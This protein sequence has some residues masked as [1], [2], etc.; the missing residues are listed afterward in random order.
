MGGGGILSVLA[1]GVS[2]GR[3]T[4][5]KSAGGPAGSGI[6]SVSVSSVSS[7]PGG[8]LGA[9]ISSSDR[10]GKSG[11]LASFFA[12]LASS[13]RL[14]GDVAAFFLRRRFS[15]DPR[16]ISKPSSGTG[17][18]VSEAV[19]LLAAAG[20]VATGGVLI[21]FFGLGAAGLAS[22]AASP[23]ARGVFSGDFSGCMVAGDSSVGLVLKPFILLYLILR[24]FST[25]WGSDEIRKVQCTI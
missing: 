22:G 6:S 14:G 19:G 17:A 21:F 2:A 4:R 7:G 8:S 23:W 24:G 16:A 10:A 1:A 11:G 13:G 20:G 15:L 9:S 12:G 25:S 5:R 3:G 18:G